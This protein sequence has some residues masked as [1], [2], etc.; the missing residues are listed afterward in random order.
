MQKEI[1]VIWTDLNEELFKFIFG[2]VKEEQIAKDILQ[3]TFVKVI[4]KIEQLEHTSKLTSWV[5][6]IARNTIFDYY[7]KLNLKNKAL[8]RLELPEDEIEDFEYA[9][10]SSCINSKI[11]SLSFKHKQAILL[12]SFKDYSQKELA[13]HLNISYSGIKSRIQKAREILKENILDCHNVESDRTGKLLD[14]NTNL[15]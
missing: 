9:Q 8:D 3:E 12:T 7:R 2:K 11:K 14:F 4:A 13:T 10:L 6:Q 5:Y 1:K 15:D